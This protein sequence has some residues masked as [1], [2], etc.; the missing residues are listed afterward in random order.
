MLELNA[1]GQPRPSLP[2][3]RPAPALPSAPAPA[4]APAWQVKGTP[5]QNL[6]LLP[7]QMHVGSQVASLR[8]LLGSCV[9][10][11]VWHPGRRVGG[12][13][14]FL[15]PQRTRRNGEALDGRY[16]DEAVEAM[17]TALRG[18]RAVPQECT[19]HL[20]G[21]ADTMPDGAGVKFSV[22]ERNI[23]Q[24]W[25]LIDHYGFSLDG[26]DV[27]ED[28]PRTV[29]L[30]LSDGAVEM[31]RGNGR[32][33]VLAAAAPQALPRATTPAPLASPTRRF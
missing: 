30:S 26:V 13:C 21:G 12:M 25:S 29:N 10:I 15:L 4:S 22:G 9:A 16:G 20:Y 27:G 19:A 11:V 8:T 24:G 7:G 6:V 28:I 31:R 32:A 33:P 3:K 2:V 5:G 1:S 23:E 14:H 17:V 18:L